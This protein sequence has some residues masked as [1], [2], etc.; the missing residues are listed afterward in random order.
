MKQTGG[1]R[2]GLVPYIFKFRL[3][4]L[5]L[6]ARPFALFS[7]ALC[8]NLLLVESLQTARRTSNVQ[9]R[10]IPVRWRCH[11][12]TR[13]KSKV[14]NSLFAVYFTHF[15]IDTVT[16]LVISNFVIATAAL[17]SI[18]QSCVLA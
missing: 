2:N 18:G 5:F 4:A 16:N 17:R 7:V 10:D 12:T 3:N 14:T 8:R 1:H 15:V 13:P 9:S 6:N 11:P